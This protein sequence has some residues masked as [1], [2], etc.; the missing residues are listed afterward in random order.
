MIFNSSKAAPVYP[1]APVGPGDAVDNS[2]DLSEVN[3]FVNKISFN[4]RHSTAAMSR[5]TVCNE[6][7]EMAQCNKCSSTATTMGTETSNP[8]GASW[9]APT[10]ADAARAH[11]K[12]VM[13]LAAALFS[14]ANPEPDRAMRE[15]TD[16]VSQ[17]G[18]QCPA[19]HPTR[20]SFNSRT[21]AFEDCSCGYGDSIKFYADRLHKT[22][23]GEGN[24]ADLAHTASHL[25]V[26]HALSADE[27]AQRGEHM[28]AAVHEDAADRL[29]RELDREVPFENP[30]KQGKSRGAQN[31]NNI[32]SP[33]STKSTRMKRFKAGIRRVGRILRE[34]GE[35]IPNPRGLAAEQVSL[36]RS[37]RREPVALPRPTR[38][39]SSGEAIEA[40]PTLERKPKKTTWDETNTPYQRQYS[41]NRALKKRYESR[42]SREGGKAS[43]EAERWF[44]TGAH[45]GDIDERA[46]GRTLGN[47]GLLGVRWTVPT[48]GKTLRDKQQQRQE[49]FAGNTGWNANNE[50]VSTER[51]LQEPTFRVKTTHIDPEH[52]ED[53][54]FGDS[55]VPKS[56]SPNHQGESGNFVDSPLRTLMTHH[57]AANRMHHETVEALMNHPD[58]QPVNG[59]IQWTPQARGA[60][61]SAVDDLRKRTFEMYHGKGTTTGTGQKVGP[62][63]ISK[64]F[65]DFADKLEQMEPHPED[66]SKAEELIR[67]LRH[68]SVGTDARGTLDRIGNPL[69][70]VYDMSLHH[71]TQGSGDQALKDTIGNSVGFTRPPVSPLSDDV[72][73]FQQVLEHRMSKR[74]VGKPVTDVEELA[75]RAAPRGT[76]K[77][78]TPAAPP[79]SFNSENAP[80][81]FP[82][83]VKKIWQKAYPEQ[84]IKNVSD[85]LKPK[86]ETETAPAAPELARPK[87]F[88]SPHIEHTS[89]EG[90]RPGERPNR[91]YRA[92][93]PITQETSTAPSKTFRAPAPIRPSDALVG[94]TPTPKYERIPEPN[95]VETSGESTTTN[96]KFDITPDQAGSGH[97]VVT[98]DVLETLAAEHQHRST[99]HKR[100]IEQ[101]I[102]T[103]RKMGDLSEN[104]DYQAAKDEQGK[105]EMRLRDLEGV[106]SNYKVIKHNPDTS[107]V[108]LGHHVRL[109]FD[110]DD[111]KNAEEYFV[112]SPIGAT[113][114]ANAVSPGSDLG[115]RIL[116]RGVGETIEYPSPGGVQ[117][118]K[119]LGIR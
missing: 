49:A 66:A 87:Y 68:T 25:S 86:V 84:G 81:G 14:G 77:N 24:G 8:R 29:V 114:G 36:D 35:P 106:L 59:K 50:Y 94:P 7:S 40:N 72:T 102:D 41:L 105:N 69:S 21:A 43:P 115:K 42:V 3:E 74:E 119:I 47:S 61:T 16:H 97:N 111:E 33:P 96:D 62:S 85:I 118:A 10:P 67:A 79:R 15:I 117:K 18:D 82:G 70:N 65:G 34:A 80:E 48:T 46:L 56:S 113:V 13:T 63:F 88:T 107:K 26:L 52:G 57:F 27:H 12:S 30:L 101:R 98:R 95:K 4:S 5:C 64:Q 91:Y 60:V 23:T 54:M 103:A 22:V 112:G 53:R 6:P 73:H 31:K 39:N 92:P 90:I 55:G 89:E 100:G 44:G 110:G 83:L 1:T 51:L 75:E 28:L 19:C 116:G 109:H 76:N 37:T 38:Y 58:L 2:F 20:L 93:A 78:I 9:H 71:E 32:A 99:T 104:G 11:H 17:Y 45:E 108:D